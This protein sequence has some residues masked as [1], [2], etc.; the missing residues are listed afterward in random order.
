M[1]GVAHIRK[2]MAKESACQ[3]HRLCHWLRGAWP[4]AADS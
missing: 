3:W 1:K 4:M 2:A